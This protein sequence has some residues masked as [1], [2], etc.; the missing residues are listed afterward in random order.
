MVQISKSAL[1]EY[2]QKGPAVAQY[3]DNSM[4]IMMPTLGMV[5]WKVW[6]CWDEMRY[7]MNQ[8]RFIMDMQGMEVGEAYNSMVESSLRINA[9]RPGGVRFVLM[10]EDDNLPD[11]DCLTKLLDAI[12]TCIDCGA[13]ID[14]Q[15][16]IKTEKWECVNGHKGLDAVSGLYFGK[17]DPPEPFIFGDPK[18]D[19]TNL[20]QGDHR[21]EIEAEK[22]IEVNAVPQ[23]LLLIRTSLFNEV[24]K[25]WF[26][27]LA[28][29]NGRF[30]LTQDI[31]FC[32]KAKEE[33]GARFAVHCGAHV[34]HIDTGSGRIY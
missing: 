6:R 28:G 22:V 32:K 30:T 14:E 4:I 15:K 23:G 2:M 1:E 31:Y 3:R 21:E 27:T 9:S 34:G 20:V 13:E 24:S 16:F 33:V 11:S 10:R 8:W 19:S 26:K 17:V 18:I 29:N 7:P 25:P 12:Y 5:H